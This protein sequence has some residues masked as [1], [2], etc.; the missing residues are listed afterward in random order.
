MIEHLSD[1]LPGNFSIRGVEQLGITDVRT[2]PYEEVV[3]EEVADVKSD[4]YLF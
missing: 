2:N 3:L 1:V 4:G